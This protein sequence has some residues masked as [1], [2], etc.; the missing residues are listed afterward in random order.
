[1]SVVASL[2]SAD[3]KVS[4]EEVTK[5]REFCETIQ[6][7]DIGVS[8]IIAAIENPAVV[9]LASILPRLAQTDLKF[10]L[11]ADMLFMAIGAGKR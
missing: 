11:L 1:M 5:I 3:G 7:G 10:T 9:D 2:A 4:D 6:I 8:L